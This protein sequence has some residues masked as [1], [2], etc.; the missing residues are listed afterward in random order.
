MNAE[1]SEMAL[2]HPC[3]LLIMSIFLSLRIVC[4]ATM[5]EDIML[6]VWVQN[7]CIPTFVEGLAWWVI[8]DHTWNCLFKLVLTHSF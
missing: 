8:V 2:S 4:G 7:E 6:I 1:L 3:C 5:T